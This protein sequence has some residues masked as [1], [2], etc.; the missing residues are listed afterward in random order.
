MARQRARRPHP[1]V[2]TLIHAMRLPLR[3]RRANPGPLPLSTG[4]GERRPLGMTMAAQ[5]AD[6]VIACR[7]QKGRITMRLARIASDG[8]EGIARR[9]ATAHLERD[10]Q[11]FMKA[12][13]VCEVEIEGNW[14]A[15][16]PG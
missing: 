8:R 7:A 1:G 13:D 9:K 14:A 4:G 6:S 12:G 11:L 2:W 5:R 16:Q 10:S 3:A 15:E